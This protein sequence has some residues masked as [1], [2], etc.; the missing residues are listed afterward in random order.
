[1]FALLLA[2]T[3]KNLL[4][5]DKYQLPWRSYCTLTPEFPPTSPALN[6]LPPVGLFIGVMSTAASFQRRQLIRSTWA[7]HPR[8]RGGVDGKSG[9]EGTSRTVVR[10][11]IG[12]PSPSLKDKLDLENERKCSR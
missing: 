11:I 5:P 6:S 3:I 8:S 2:F 9:L 1:M 4:D 7:S 10:F 12:T